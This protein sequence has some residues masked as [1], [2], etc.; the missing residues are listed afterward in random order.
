MPARVRLHARV[1]SS[2]TK[3]T[4][5]NPS[6]RARDPASPA[7]RRVR[8]MYAGSSR[9]SALAQRGALPAISVSKKPIYARAACTTPLRAIAGGGLAVGVEFLEFEGKDNP[10][11][12]RH[13][14]ITFIFNVLPIPPQLNAQNPL[15]TIATASF[16]RR[17]HPT[18]A[19]RTPHS[20]DHSL[21]R[22]QPVSLSDLDTM[23]HPLQPTR[24]LLVFLQRLQ[25]PAGRA[26]RR[27][28]HPPPRS[29]PNHLY[30]PSEISQLESMGGDPQVRVIIATKSPAAAWTGAALLAGC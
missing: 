28:Q 3:N 18:A 5:N 10:G 12:P 16:Q 21:R 24:R 6:M 27:Y 11:V 26:Y 29:P 25:D 15:P 20:Q 17:R 19:S 7:P 14:I 8:F 2:L 4:V 9:L 1:P 22:R 13:V 23:P 30:T